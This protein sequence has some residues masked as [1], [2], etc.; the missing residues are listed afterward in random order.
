[1]FSIERLFEDVREHLPA[2]IT[3]TTCVNRH[4]SRGLTP[5]LADAVR[6]RGSQGEVN[7]V[8]GDVHYLTY[9]L[10]RRRTV[11]TIHDCV[12][13]QRTR[14]LRHW[15]LRE[16]WY[17]IPVHKARVI[18]VIS[19]ATR[20]QVASYTGCSL[21]KVRVIPNCVS[22]VYRHCPKS[23]RRDRPRVL[24]VGTKPNKNLER[25]AAA[26]AGL[27]CV[28]VVVG[29]LSARQEAYLAEKEVAVENY[30]DLSLE[31]LVDQYRRC[32]LLL[33]AST[34]EGFGLPI[35]E[36]QAVGRPVVTSNC[37]SM[38]EVAGG[39]AQLVDPFDVASIR[40][41]LQRVL[42]D[43]DYRTSLIAQGLE[44]VKRFRPEA[45]AEQ[46]AALYRE[47]YE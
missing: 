16:L 36:A 21:E 40:E 26:M 46:Y 38:P 28:L 32:D 6:A 43:P 29:R 13:L 2:D 8:T 12:A 33:F 18:T 39:A 4:P 15:L 14:G 27:G 45:I 17:R 11:L 19:E 22:S 42:A 5:R 7:H 25:H 44:N 24:H 10:D 31:A 41:G 9:L 1:M 23:F 35:V 30:V 37:F 3:A 47:V 20:R 34:Y